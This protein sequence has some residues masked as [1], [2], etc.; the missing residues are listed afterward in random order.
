[1]RLIYFE[2]LLAVF[3]GWDSSVNVATHYG[4]DGPG[5]ESRSRQDFLHLF[6]LALGPTQLPIRWVPGFSQG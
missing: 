2:C 4:L 5:T 6:R 1:M 3:L